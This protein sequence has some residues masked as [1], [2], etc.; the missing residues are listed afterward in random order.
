MFTADAKTLS[1][2]EPTVRR[3][4]IIEPNAASARL[5]SDL[6]KGLGAREIYV[7]S[8]EERAVELL[9][10]VEPVVVFTEYAGPTLSGERL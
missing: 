9:R 7:E 10:D 4:A 2:I 5:M 8:D 6:I 1:R 3:V